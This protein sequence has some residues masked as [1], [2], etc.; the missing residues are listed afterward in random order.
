MKEIKKN[1]NKINSP[2]FFLGLI[3]LIVAIRFVSEVPLWFDI[4]QSDDNGYLLAGINFFKTI[5]IRD[6]SWSPLYLLWFFSLHKITPAPAKIYYISMQLI[7][8][9]T[10]IFAFLLLRKMRVNLLLAILTAVFFLASYAIWIPEPRVT[11]FST[12][13]LLFLWWATSF[14]KKRWQRLWGMASASLLFAYSRPEFFLVTI[15]LSVIAI[16]YLG[17]S[18]FKKSILRTRLPKFA[19]AKLKVK[20]R[21]KNFRDLPRTREEPAPPPFWERLGGGKTDF[22][23]LAFSSGIVIFFLIWWGIPFSASRSIYAFGQHYAENAKYCISN[24]PPSNQSWEEILARNFNNPKSMGEALR[25]NPLNF[26]RHLACNLKAFPKQLLKVAFSSAWGSSWLLIR[27]WIAF[28][29]YRLIVHWAEIKKRF[30]WLWQKDFLLFGILSL[31]VLSID[32]ILI[33]P[34]EHYLTLT[35]IIVWVLGISLFGNFPATTQKNWRQSIAIALSLLLLTPSLGALFDFEIPQKPVLKTIETIHAL[36]LN[37][38][39]RLFGTNPFQTSRSK[40]YFA[41]DYVPIPPKPAEVPFETYIADY[42]PN[43][44]LITKEGWLFREDATWLAF[45]ANPQD[46]GFKQ[47]PFEAGDEFGIWRIYQRD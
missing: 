26:R 46:F 18:L 22:I 4:A 25:A 27:I 3:L 29:I 38:P 10:P 39:L 33:Y 35:T 14:F 8:V 23:F 5:N 12:L 42:Q 37:E 19:S 40:V 7:G 17:Y 20:N 28:I 13:I 34:R 16:S 31:G 9:L 43:I 1:L 45:E 36:E 2:D 21:D 44:I 47:L 24:E 6:A 41:N 32:I 30:I 15:A 11:S